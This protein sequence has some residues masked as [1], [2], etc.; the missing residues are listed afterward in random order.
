MT[1]RR[2]TIKAATNSRD[3]RPSSDPAARQGDLADR[4][5]RQTTHVCTDSCEDPC[6]HAV[7]P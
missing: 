7:S 6:V 4:H 5:V 2:Q 1:T 3:V